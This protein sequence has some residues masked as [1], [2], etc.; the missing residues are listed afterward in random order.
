LKN[1]GRPPDKLGT[2]MVE[3]AYPRYP[4]ARASAA[5][6]HEHFVRHHERAR[7]EGTTA[8]A[9]MPDLGAIERII[10]VAFWASL[11]RE[12]G[13]S[14]RISLAYVPAEP[15]PDPLLFERQLPL[16]PAPLAKLAPAVERPGI[17]LGVWQDDGGEFG[18][19]GT[20]R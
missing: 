9:P 8:L 14:P 4:A 6:I 3:I 17:H 15:S 13:R 7:R 18:V 16:V 11:R 12:E 19:W 1:D 20:T 10:D 5:R 2:Q